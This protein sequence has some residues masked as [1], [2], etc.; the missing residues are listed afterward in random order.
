MVE[1][2][3][4]GGSKQP[5]YKAEKTTTEKGRAG[6]DV[7]VLALE[8]LGY[9]V[10]ERNARTKGGE[11]DV[12]A[13]DG[14]VLCFIEVRRRKKIEDALLS[15]NAR[16]QQPIVRAATA[17]LTRLEPLPV[18]RFDVVV[19]AHPEVHVVRGAFEAS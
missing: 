12:V 15:I 17:W 18:C 14:P 19:L 2:D 4:S 5:P 1:R 6:E 8:R 3:Q 11:I 10:V 7:A 13:W 9:S 16:K